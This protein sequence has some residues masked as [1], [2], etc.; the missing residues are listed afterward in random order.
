MLA[1]EN[2]DTPPA[3]LCDIAAYPHV[4]RDVFA[5]LGEVIRGR[6]RERLVEIGGGLA[7]WLQGQ[8]AHGMPADRRLAAEVLR[9]FDNDATVA[10]LHR[11]LD[12]SEADVR[13]AAALALAELG[14]SPPLAVLVLRLHAGSREHS[15]LLRRLFRLIA[16]QQPTDV[17]RVAE[18]SLG[19]GELR[20]F[21]IDALAAT[22]DGAWSG[23]LR[24][25]AFDPDPAVRTAAVTGLAALGQPDVA[26][27]L[28]DVMNDP[29]WNVRAAAVDA[30]RRLDLV[31]LVPA[32]AQRLDDPVWWVAFRA[33]DALAALGESGL[34]ALRALA[35]SEAERRGRIAAAVIGEHQL[36]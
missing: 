22:G 15:L 5:E 17:M 21:A 36:A 14:H 16:A 12:D 34:A 28:A 18:G 2:E 11:A 33:A 19:P 27:V 29:S 10:A 13:L 6:S 4:A 32:I 7:G 26:D 20:P 25:L 31:E 1:T 3:L 8:L 35:A 9:L 24:V 30:A 23:A